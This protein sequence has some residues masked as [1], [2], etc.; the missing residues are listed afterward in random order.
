M[1]EAWS[2]SPEWLY[3]VGTNISSQAGNFLQALEDLNDKIDPLIAA[4][5]SDNGEGQTGQAMQQAKTD[6]STAA[7]QL[8]QILTSIGTT[9]QELSSGYTSADQYTASRI[10]GGL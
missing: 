2:V 10:P 4:N 8:Q 7:T 6:W 5:M 1:S 9:T 3:Q